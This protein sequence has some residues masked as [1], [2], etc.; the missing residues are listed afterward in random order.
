VK[1][2]A[3][4]ALLLAGVGILVALPF[5]PSIQAFTNS[6]NERLSTALNTSGFA[7]TPLAPIMHLWN[8]WALLLII[9]C[10]V[11]IFIGV[12]KREG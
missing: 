1:I 3:F 11:I 7:D 2:G 10:V 9:V 5:L 4:I 8:V 6:S 12:S